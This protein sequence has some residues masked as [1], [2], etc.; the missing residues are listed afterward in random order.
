MARDV[1]HPNVCRV[2]DIGEIDGHPFLSMEYIDGENLASLLRRIGRLPHDTAVEMARQLCAGLAAAHEQGRAPSRPEARERDDRRPRQGPARGLRACRRW[3]TIGARHA[4]AGTPAYMAP[5]LFDRTAAV[6]AVRHLRARARAVRDV[7]RASRPFSRRPIGELARAAPRID[8]DQPVAHRVGRRSGGRTRHP[9]LPG[10]GSGRSAGVGAGGRG[11][12]AGRRSAGGGARG[13]RDAVAGDGGGRRRRRRA[14]PVSGGRVRRGR[15]RWLWRRRPAQRRTQAIRYAPA[16]RAPDDTGRPGAIDRC[17]PRVHRSTAAIPRMGS[18]APTTS[19]ICGPAIGRRRA[20]RICGRGSRPASLSG[21]AQSPSNSTTDRFFCGGRVTLSDPPLRIA[22]RGRRSCSTCSGRLHQLM[23]CAADS[24]RRPAVSRARLECVVPRGGLRPRALHAVVAR[25]TPPVFADTRAA[26]DGVYPDRPDMAIHIEAASVGGQ[27]GVLPDLRAVERGRRSCRRRAARRERR[28]DSPLTVCAGVFF[29]AL[30][31][32]RRNLRLGRGDQ[33]GAF[34]LALV[35]FLA[36]V[37]AGLLGA[38]LRLE[39]SSWSPAC[40]PC[41]SRADCCIGGARLDLLR[42]DRAGPATP[43]AAHADLVDTRARR[44]LHGSAGRPRHPHRHRGRNR[45]PVV[46]TGWDTSPPR[47]LGGAPGV[48]L[49]LRGGPGHLRGCSRGGM[50]LVPVQRR[51]DRHLVR[52]VGVPA[53]PGSPP[54]RT[55]RTVRRRR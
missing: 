40:S 20:G 9:A 31:L 51:P 19:G 49:P 48:A 10:K 23:A 8:A 30:L 37:A 16:E 21:I 47:W 33:V 29:G 32:V 42:R 25:W 44:A 17:A 35:L 11:R 54:P 14:Q 1:S 50:S 6:G 53:A 2:Y 7:R 13:G 27:A 46:D 3:R 5:E 22:R 38:D 45:S 36:H 55:G 12:A 28:R 26:W 4:L 43:F 52:A 24:T 39:S 34:R 41:W 15:V 18:R